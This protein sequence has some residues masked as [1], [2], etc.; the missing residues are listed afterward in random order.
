M[1]QHV[2]LKWNKMFVSSGKAEWSYR[3]DKLWD[4]LSFNFEMRRPS[5]RVEEPRRQFLLLCFVSLREVCCLR[6]RPSPRRW[7]R[8]TLIGRTPPEATR[9]RGRPLQ[10]KKHKELCLLT[11]SLHCKWRITQSEWKWDEVCVV[12]KRLFSS[13]QENR[14]LTKAFF[15]TM[16][17]IEKEQV[18]TA[19]TLIWHL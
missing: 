17:H 12:M 19:A 15:T 5:C 4:E 18:R 16:I 9:K 3:W 13:L 6:W 8:A 14:P 7:K 11:T 2:S 10:G 1:T